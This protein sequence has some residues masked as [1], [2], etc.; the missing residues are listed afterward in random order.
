VSRTPTPISTLNAQV[1]VHGAT[2]HRRAGSITGVRQAARAALAQAYPRGACEWTVRLSDDAELRQLNR[3]YRGIDQPT[4]VLSF[5]GERY[6][7]GKPLPEPDAHTP[8]EADGP[9]YLGDIIISMLRCAA[10]AAA[11]GHSTD[12]ELA[13]LVVHGT[14]H[15]LGYDHDTPARKARMWAAQAR[16]LQSIGIT[17]DVP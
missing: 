7:D 3:A 13:L 2:A 12:T 4:D 1:H 11:S 9:E 10:Q 17:V 5:G 14:L 8:Q 16:A 6:R 15:L